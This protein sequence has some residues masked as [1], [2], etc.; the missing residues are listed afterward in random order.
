MKKLFIFLLSTLPLT[1]MAQVDRSKAPAPAPAPEIKVGKPATFT[2]PNG[3]RV[4]VVQNS[5]LPRVSATLTIDSDGIIEGNKAG[6]TGIAGELLR[7]GTT[8]MNKAKLDDEIDYLGANVSTSPWSVSAASLKTNFPKV[9][10]LVGD[11]VLRPALPAAELEKIRK[12]ALSGLQANKDDPSAIADNVVNRLAY[13]KE[14]PYGDIETEQTI[15]N[16][17]LEDVRSFFRTYWNPNNAFLVFVGDIS[18]EEARVLATKT[19]GTWK[20]GVLPIKSYKAPQPPAKTFI[21]I[22]DRPA[23]VQSV[24]NFI[25]PIEL[26]PGTPDV[27]PASVMNNILGSGSSSRLFLNLREKHGFTYG[28]YSNIKSDRLVGAFSAEASVRNEKTDSAIGQFIYEF[29]RIRNDQ[30]DDTTVRN[31]KNNL[32]GSFA[33]SLENPSTIANFALNTARY[34]LPE[35]YYQ[36]YLKNLAAVNPQSAQSVA[37]K[38]VNPGR[39]LIVVVGNA[40]EV[41][42]GLEKYGEVRYFDMYGNPVATP[43]EKKVDADVTAESILQKAV[44]AAGGEAA[45]KALKDLQLSGTVSVMGQQLNISQKHVFP[46]AY[47]LELGVQGMVLQKKLLKN[48]NYSV[49]AQGQD[50]QPEATDKEEMNEEAAFV[51]EM[52]ML[53]QP[54]YQ[55]TLSGIEQ[56]EG[57]DVYVLKVKSP[58]GRDYTNYY[59][60]ASGLKVKTSAQRDAGPMGQ[61]TIG[62]TYSD[63]KPYA[64]V[65]VPTK[66]TINQGPVKLDVAFTDIKVNSGLKADDVK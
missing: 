44:T 7:R 27:I 54:G 57:K 53:S 61:L 50:Q 39:L 56:V 63:Y 36:N 58:A 49:S 33:R 51:S 25:S 20:R 19:F 21:A 12:Q 29:N 41:A 23:S 28:A 18:V 32:A 14:H 55:Y 47:S 64:G 60:V 8:T 11:I 37:R 26:K 65:Q 59:D 22:V 35:N 16:V 30:L 13:G 3:L 40:K 2:L 38:Y 10:S 6:L 48:G 52:Y 15:N 17:K 24:I 9:M 45:I 1:M 34:K 62:V 5:K 46:S 31:M 66:M 43:V 42:P 4:F